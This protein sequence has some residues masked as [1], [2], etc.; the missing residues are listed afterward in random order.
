LKRSGGVYTVYVEGGT[1]LGFQR[2][3]FIESRDA[4]DPFIETVRIY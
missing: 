1:A 2:G 3:L 4:A